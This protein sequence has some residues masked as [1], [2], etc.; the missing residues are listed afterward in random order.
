MTPQQIL[1]AIATYGAPEIQAL[2]DGLCPCLA[3]LPIAALLKLADETA[4]AVAAKN[5]L[6]A[7]RAGAAAADAQADAAEEAALKS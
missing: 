2:V 5:E 4:K 7:M 1:D 3:V 6:E